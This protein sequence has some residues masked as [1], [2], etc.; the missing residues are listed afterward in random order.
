MWGLSPI[1]ELLA[2]HQSLLAEVEL[3][4]FPKSIHLRLA[5]WER[6]ISSVKYLQ[7]PQNPIQMKVQNERQL[8][9]SFAIY[10]G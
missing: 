10:S 1:S 9:R 2:A 7:A 6:G 8:A 3:V 5:V 4:Q